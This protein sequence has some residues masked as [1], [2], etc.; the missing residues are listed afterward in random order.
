M[1]IPVSLPNFRSLFG[2][3]IQ[4]KLGGKTVIGVI[5]DCGG[6]DGGARAIDVQPG[7]FHAFGYGSCQA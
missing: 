6:L 2:H 1:S 7:I 5:N 3:A 4:I